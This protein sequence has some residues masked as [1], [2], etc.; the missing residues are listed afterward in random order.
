MKFN[1][2][3]MDN[4]CNHK[5]FFNNEHVLTNEEGF[6]NNLKDETYGVANR[7]IDDKR[8]Y[9][10]AFDRYYKKMK[11]HI[12][13]SE[14]DYDNVICENQE[15]TI[16]NGNF[17][18]LSILGFCGYHS[19]KEKFKFIFDSGEVLEQRIHM[20]HLMESFSSL[21]DCEMDERCEMWMQ[22]KLNTNDRA[23][24]FRTNCEI[25]NGLKRIKLPNNPDMHIISITLYD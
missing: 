4:I 12:N 1:L 8:F 22:V 16:E 3:N 18:K 9:Y 14:S 25:A 10:G 21:Y 2:V 20:Y 15:I 5:I 19:Y 11:F 17:T 24:I 7:W 6:R 23:K 13:G